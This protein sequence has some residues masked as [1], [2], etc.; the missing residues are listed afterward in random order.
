MLYVYI[1]IL[2]IYI[3]IIQ[4]IFELHLKRSGTQ[5]D[6][7]TETYYLDCFLQDLNA[8]ASLRQLEISQVRKFTKA[9]NPRIPA[10]PSIL[11][12]QTTSLLGRL[13]RASQPE[14]CRHRVPNQGVSTKVYK[15][16]L[17]L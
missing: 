13:Q 14:K 11:C 2:N 5:L 15:S 9:R 6:F 3:Y 16:T 4:Y 8:Q 17:K 12:T 10:V 1:Y 7:N